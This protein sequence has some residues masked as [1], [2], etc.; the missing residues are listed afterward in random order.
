MSNFGTRTSS[1]PTVLILLS[2]SLITNLGISTPALLQGYGQVEFHRGR[3][4]RYLHGN[5]KWFRVLVE[6]GQLS[7]N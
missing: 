6:H 4:C 3:N 2:T 5:K 7:S 1:D